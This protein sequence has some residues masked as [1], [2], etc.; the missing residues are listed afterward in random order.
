MKQK[1]IVH[2]AKK[3]VQHLNKMILGHQEM[4]QRLN[5]L[6]KQEQPLQPTLEQHLLTNGLPAHLAGKVAQSRKVGMTN[7]N[8]S[9]EHDNLLLSILQGKG[10]ADQAKQVQEGDQKTKDREHGLKEKELSIKEQE[11]KNNKAPTADEVSASL[12]KNLK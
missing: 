10:M 8:G 4:S 12:L 7:Y 1:I 9:K 6:P 3:A 2:T 5:T 11:I